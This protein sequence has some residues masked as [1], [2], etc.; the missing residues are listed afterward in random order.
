[1]LFDLSIRKELS[2]HFWASAFIL[3][4]IVTTLAFIRTLDL[5][6]Q[7]RLNPEEI[8]LALAY[9]CLSRLPT[10]LTITLLITSASVLIRMYKDSEMPIWH[11]AGLSLWNFVSPFLRFA[12]PLWILIFLLQ[13]WVWP[14]ANEQ[15][16]ALKNRYEQRDDLQRIHPGKF[17]E[18]K[19]GQ[20][21][22]YIGQDSSNPSKAKEIFI[23]TQHPSGISI[24]TAQVGEIIHNAHGQY[25]QVN[26]GY[27]IDQL[28]DEGITRNIAFDIYTTQVRPTE[29]QANI[30][31]IDQQASWLLWKSQEKEALAELSWRIGMGLMSINMV[32]L[33]LATTKIQTRSAK[34]ASIA[35]TIGVALIY[36]NL[37]TLGKAWISIGSIDF[38][39]WTL[40]LHGTVLLGCVSKLL[41]QHFK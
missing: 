5:A 11:G 19:D 41:Y 21:V 12:W 1:M 31:N 8:T 9:A 24:L 26:Q 25:L 37:L 15:T 2:R 29:T 10:I 18:S 20:K 34:G 32:F 23:Q 30:Q 17:Q 36:L 33:A 39:S 16:N 14:W 40:L 27:R 13:L 3:L 22:F 28:V 35:F 4:A 38:L 7:G 6:D